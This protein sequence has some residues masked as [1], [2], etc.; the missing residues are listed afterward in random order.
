[1]LPNYAQRLKG[2]R[3]LGSTPKFRIVAVNALYSQRSS[4]DGALQHGPT[5]R[6]NASA[7][8]SGSGAE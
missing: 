7:P 1:M 3:S 5:G 4:L 6:S 8:A 2:S